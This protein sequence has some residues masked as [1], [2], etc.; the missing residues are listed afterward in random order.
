M[1]R[2][3]K[4]CAGVTAGINH[5]LFPIYLITLGIVSP[6][7]SCSHTGEKRHC[8]GLQ[9][10]WSC[11]SCCHT[12]TDTLS[13]SGKLLNLLGI[14][15]GLAIPISESQSKIILKGTCSLEKTCSMFSLDFF[16]PVKMGY[17]QELKFHLNMDC[18]ENV[19]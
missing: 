4:I 13:P 16:F 18:G 17:S 19:F 8:Q 9:P 11:F 7:P 3:C 12:T 2:T 14:N 5:S 6:M 15:L 10:P 1:A